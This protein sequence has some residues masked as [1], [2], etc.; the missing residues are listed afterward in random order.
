MDQRLQKLYNEFCLLKDKLNSDNVTKKTASI[1]GRF[2]KVVK[3]A[4]EIVSNPPK[5]DR[6]FEQ[7]FKIENYIPILQEKIK[8]TETTLKAK[9][10]AKI[11]SQKNS[12][13][14]KKDGTPKQK[15]G[16]KD[17]KK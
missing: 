7:D 14:L 1:I 6:S 11:E 16:P 5:V 2:A 3:S 15:P 17:K 8:K 9:A 12:S 4:E 13:N 10:K